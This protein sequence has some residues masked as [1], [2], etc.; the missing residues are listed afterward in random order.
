MNPRNSWLLAALLA[1]S[2][3]AWAQDDPEKPKDDPT[4]EALRSNLEDL[5]KV[6]QKKSEETRKETIRRNQQDTL[7]IYERSLN[8]NSTE[9]SN[10]S[11]RLQVNHGIIEKY[12]KSLDET[13]EELAKLQAR[14]VSRTLALKK[15]LDEGKISQ[16]TYDRLL[17]E[18]GQKFRNREAELKEDLEFYSKEI[19]T[20]RKLVKELTLRKELLEIDPFQPEKPGEG[21]N[22]S[23]NLADRVRNRIESVAG[24]RDLSV[25]ETLK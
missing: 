14:Y 9:I 5:E 12:Q 18:D 2:L 3:G 13:R 16:D 1:P 8:R 24:F 4:F 20:A 10:V 25:I 6:E 22:S 21:E 11:R 7:K 19:E 15:S 23:A 17:D